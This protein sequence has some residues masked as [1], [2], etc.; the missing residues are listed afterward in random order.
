MRES[1]GGLVKYSKNE[2][3]YG[4]RTACLTMLVCP[5]TPESWLKS[6]KQ[7]KIYL[8]RKESSPSLEAV[9]NSCTRVALQS[10]RR[11]VLGCDTV[12]EEDDA[13]LVDQNARL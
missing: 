5:Y 11:L 3:D 4:F 13:I 9:R 2:V 12:N 10:R 6:R 7:S 8:R 1:L